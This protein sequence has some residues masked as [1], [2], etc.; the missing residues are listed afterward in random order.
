MKP[1]RKTELPAKL[2]ALVV[3]C[4]RLGRCFRFRPALTVLRELFFKN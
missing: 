1:T 3:G 4:K 2:E